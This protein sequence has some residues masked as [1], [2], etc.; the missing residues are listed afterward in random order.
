MRPPMGKTVHD[1]GPKAAAAVREVEALTSEILSVMQ[2]GGSVDEQR[3][4]GQSRPV[5]A[6]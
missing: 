6:G 1:L 4:V 2:L 5:A 3:P